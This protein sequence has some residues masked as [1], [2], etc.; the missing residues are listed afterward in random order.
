M[1]ISERKFD[2]RIWALVAQDLRVYIFK[3]GYIRT[4]GEKFSLAS[5]DVEKAQIHLT[6]NAV[7]KNLETYGA[8]EDG[9]QLSYARASEVTGI[10]FKEQIVPQTREIIVETM[11][12]INEG[13]V[14]DK[15]K[16]SCFELFGYDFMVDESQ[17]VWLLEVNTNPCLEES[18][19]LL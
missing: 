13:L 4:S 10:S 2:I 14:E 19:K 7:Q 5:E 16:R 1:L 6:N 12:S 18:S 8:F 17:K 15:S 3:E 9:N 11:K